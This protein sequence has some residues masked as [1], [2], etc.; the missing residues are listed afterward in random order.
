MR[1]LKEFPK[2]ERPPVLLTSMAFKIM[3]GLGSFFCLIT[4]IGWFLRDRLSDYP[5]FLKLMI[6]SI[7]LPYIATSMGWIVT[8]VGRQP[9]IVYG[10]M[11]TS[12][13]VSPVDP[14]QVFISLVAFILVYGVI[15]AIG[16]YLIGKHAMNGPVSDK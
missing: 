10:L 6:A 14:V 9:W 12:D 1:G 4:L 8:E 15:G 7:P 2:D 16:F 13:A 5:L 3:V 11:K